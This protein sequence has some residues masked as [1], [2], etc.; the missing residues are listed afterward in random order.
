M[1]QHSLKKCRLVRRLLG[2]QEHQMN[3]QGRL[4][5]IE[6]TLELYYARCRKLNREKRRLQARIER[7]ESCAAYLRQF[8]PPYRQA[9]LQ[10]WKRAGK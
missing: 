9:A 3:D 8:E 5:V 6:T 7:R 2:A 1:T 10:H 4:N